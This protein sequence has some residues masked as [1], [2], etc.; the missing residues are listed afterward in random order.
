MNSKLR[1][2]YLG[3]MLSALAMLGGCS[4]MQDER[5]YIE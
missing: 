4:S 5:I 1:V 3:V 2:M